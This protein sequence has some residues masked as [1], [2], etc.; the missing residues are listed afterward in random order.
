MT[1]TPVRKGLGR[2]KGRVALITGGARGIGRAIAE[3]YAAEGAIAGIVDLKQERVDAAV[4]DLKAQ[5]GEAWGVGGDVSRRETLDKAANAILEKYGRFDILVS[6]AMWARYQPLAE[7]TEENLNGMIAVGFSAVVWG[8]QIAEAIMAPRGGGAVI[9]IA[10][11]ASSRSLPNSMVYSGIKA[12]V[13]GLTRSGA[14]DLGPK[15]IRVNAIG[16]GTTLTEGVVRNVSA[17]AMDHRLSRTPLKRLGRPSDIADA[18]VFLASDES[19]WINGH[20]LY[21]DG[22]ITAAFL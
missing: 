16:P 14:V 6:N 12:G 2:L 15:N 3:A 9:N 8:M 22:G 13:V 1:D 10:S 19:A 11:V 20:V 18:A 17:E 5:G 7:L 4:A 21:V